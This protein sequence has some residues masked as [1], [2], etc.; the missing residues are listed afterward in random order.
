MTK[1][2][3]DRCGK[4]IPVGEIHV[5]TFHCGLDGFQYHLCDS[6]LGEVQKFITETKDKETGQ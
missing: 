2:F 1:Y 3:C 5:L 6:C 4:E